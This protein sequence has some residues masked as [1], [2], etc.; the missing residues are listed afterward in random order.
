MKP[1]DDL[2]LFNKKFTSSCCTEQQVTNA[3]KALDTLLANTKSEDPS[4]ES[5][6]LICQTLNNFAVFYKG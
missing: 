1:S 4:P 6:L 2:T 5:D 3:R